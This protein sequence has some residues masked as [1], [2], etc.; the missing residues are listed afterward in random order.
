MLYFDLILAA[1][2]GPT[3][4]TLLPIFSAL[5]TIGAMFGGA[6]YL[7]GKLDANS[8]ALDGRL[9]ALEAKVEALD[10]G[11]VTE[12]KNQGAQEVR[13]EASAA[14]ARQVTTACDTVAAFGARLMAHERG[15][16]RRQEEGGRQLER[17]HRELEGIRANVRNLANTTS[18]SV[19][20][21]RTT[22]EVGK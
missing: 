8:A 12:A 20:E 2:Q 17:I 1:V 3:V 16:E 6:M 22:K 7:R 11:R 9:R 15:C 13:N 19:V 10:N 21:L 18:S 4:T 14:L 5:A